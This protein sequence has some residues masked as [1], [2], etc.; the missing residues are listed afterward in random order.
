M[1]NCIRSLSKNGR[2]IATAIDS[3]KIVQKI[4]KIHETSAVVSAA[5]GRLLTAASL[6]GSTLKD[7]KSSLT[8]RVNGGGPVGTLL[9]VSDGLGNVRGYADHP[10]VEIPLREDGKLDV[11]SAVGTDG[12][13]SVIRDTG[14]GEPYIGQVPLVSGEIAE[15][16]TSYFSASEQTPCVCALGVL[17]NKDLSIQAAG[18]FLVQLLPGASEDDIQKIEENLKKIPS[19]TNLLQNNKTPQE[20]LDLLLDGLAA[21]VLDERST[22]YRCA[23]N[24]EKTRNILLSLG[25][26][27]LLDM[28]NENP[29]AGVECHFCN[30]IYRIPLAE[31]LAQSPQ[32]PADST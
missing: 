29:E 21:H 3:T 32:I 4:E 16:I 20:M 30:K 8:L 27:E 2:I 6:M 9:A 18:G 22:E 19:V 12:T 1:N 13:L 10:V 31:L 5:L 25:E 17:V 23:C 11:G 7:E 14:A 15:D 26:K 24:E 28:Q